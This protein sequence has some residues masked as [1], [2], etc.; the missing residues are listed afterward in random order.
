MNSSPLRTRL[1]A[2]M[3]GPDGEIVK[4]QIAEILN[5]RKAA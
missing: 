5:H 2:L 4:T 1:A 3:T